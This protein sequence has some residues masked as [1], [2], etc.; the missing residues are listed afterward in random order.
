ML[1]AARAL[2]DEQGLEGASLREIAKRAGYTPGALYSYFP[3]KEAIFSALL[4]ASLERLHTDIASARATQDEHLSQPA[5]QFVGR[6]QAWLRFYLQNP[7]DLSLSLTVFRSEQNAKLLAALEPVR[8]SLEVMTGSPELANTENASAYA[9]GVGLL[10]M[11]RT[12]RMLAFGQT[13]AQLFG[14]YL[15]QV[16]KRFDQSLSK[17][18]N[19]ED[20]EQEFLAR[21][22]PLF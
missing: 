8:S 15:L 22:K 16:C 13:P 12:G 6:S 21:Q 20:V 14:E 3:N 17:V 11:S 4:N 10:E 19:A 9:Y 18:R 7:K 5:K 2:F 1:E